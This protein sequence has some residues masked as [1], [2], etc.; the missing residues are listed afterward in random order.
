MSESVDTK[1]TPDQEPP[2]PVTFTSSDVIV[3]M[4]IMDVASARGCF[5]TAEMKGVGEFYE[6]LQ[7]L[8]PKKTEPSK[9]SE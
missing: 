3:V 1:A 6:K 2:T 4:N 5:R 7:G 9:K 8:V